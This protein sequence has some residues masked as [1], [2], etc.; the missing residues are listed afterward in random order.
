MKP[1]WAEFFRG[2]RYWGS[3]LF[4]ASLAVAIID[5]VRP[6][7]YFNRNFVKGW[8]IF[9]SAAIVLH[10]V[11]IVLNPLLFRWDEVREKIMEKRVRRIVDQWPEYQTL[12]HQCHYF[13]QDRM[14][15]IRMQRNKR[16]KWIK[17][18]NYQAKDYCLYW[19]LL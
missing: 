14:S 15:C 1:F 4:P 12:C 5:F 10:Y 9:W 2:K 7:L 18:E 11:R 3:V 6:D 16:V 19:R 13:D 17:M 8:A